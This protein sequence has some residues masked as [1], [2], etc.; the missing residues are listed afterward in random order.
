MDWSE[1]YSIFVV[2][3]FVMQIII[4]KILELLQRPGSHY[5]TVV[6]AEGDYIKIRVSDHSAN[7]GN[8]GDQRTLSFISER[9]PAKHLG[10]CMAEEWKVNEDGM[11]DT[12]E[13]L[14]DILADYDL[15]KT[16]K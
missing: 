4:D 14:A 2:Q 10:W 1:T 8:N 12:Y 15:V 5:F 7:R 13:E 11:T 9:T 16:L 3:L 6:T